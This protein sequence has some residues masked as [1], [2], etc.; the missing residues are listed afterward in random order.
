LLIACPDAFAQLPAPLPE[1]RFKSSGHKP[2]DG[3]HLQEMLAGNTGHRLTLVPLRD[4]DRGSTSTIYWKG[5]GTYVTFFTDALT[6]RP[7]YGHGKWKIDGDQWC[8]DTK[9]AYEGTTDFGKMPRF[10]RTCHRLYDL[11]SVIY[12]CSGTQCQTIIRMVPGNP[13]KL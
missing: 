1:S 5:D 13:E 12:E 8:Q 2:I 10:I 9:A 6:S 7:R 11:D 4:R 3:P